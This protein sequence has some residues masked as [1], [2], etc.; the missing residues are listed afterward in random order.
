MFEIT[1][2]WT[3]GMEKTEIVPR[4]GFQEEHRYFWTE[5]DLP[6]GDI[7]L[8]IYPQYNILK[9]NIVIPKEKIKKDE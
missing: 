1:I 3:A 2:T 5:D 6:N 9:I 7:Q 4:Y 8:K